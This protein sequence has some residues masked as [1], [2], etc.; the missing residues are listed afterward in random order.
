MKGLLV[1]VCWHEVWL[2]CKD[3]SWHSH[4]MPFRS[5]G[6]LR[7][8]R[9][10]SGWPISWHD[11]NQHQLFLTL[12]SQLGSWWYQQ[13][14]FTFFQI[15]YIYILIVKFILLKYYF[16]LPWINT[17]LF[18]EFYRK[19]FQQHFCFELFSFLTQDIQTKIETKK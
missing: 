12:Q 17:H 1:A 4:N 14:Y 8:P 9:W 13:I 3:D 2:L 10:A 11:N 7:R 16:V 18:K 6:E 15:E 5:R 19:P